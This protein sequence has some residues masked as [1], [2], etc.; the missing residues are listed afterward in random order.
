MEWAGASQ[1]PSLGIGR[2]A[3]HLP[4]R[5]R[6]GV[7]VDGVVLEQVGHLAAAGNVSDSQ[8]LQ[9]EAGLI[10]DGGAH[11]VPQATC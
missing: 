2:A 11:R 7:A 5:L 8:T 1:T 3:E 6:D 10:H 4:D 9:S